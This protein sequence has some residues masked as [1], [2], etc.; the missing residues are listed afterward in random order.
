MRVA[1]SHRRCSRAERFS[2]ESR[3]MLLEALKIERHVEDERPAVR[4]S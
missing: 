3:R 1:A 4:P 2:R